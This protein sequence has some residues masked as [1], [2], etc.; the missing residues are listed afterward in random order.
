LEFLI[1]F[2]LACQLAC[3]RSGLTRTHRK[4]TPK[5]ESEI[6]WLRDLASKGAAS[7]LALLLDLLAS[8]NAKL[9]KMK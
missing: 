2:L 1:L 4:S 9:G 6:A 5:E 8:A 3:L 7:A